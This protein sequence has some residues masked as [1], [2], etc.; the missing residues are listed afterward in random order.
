MS[1][2]RVYY[3]VLIATVLIKGSRKWAMLKNQNKKKLTNKHNDRL[4]KNNE[5]K[6]MWGWEMFDGLVVKCS[7]AILTLSILPLY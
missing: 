4:K 6:V 3:H 7:V 2:G 1:F 5:R